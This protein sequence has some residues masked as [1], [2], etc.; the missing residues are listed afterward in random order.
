M[1]GMGL[2]RVTPSFSHLTSIVADPSSTMKQVRSSVAEG[3]RIGSGGLITTVM[4]TEEGGVDGE[5][6]VGDGEG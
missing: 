5:G 4:M 3:G 2:G 6:G 1:T